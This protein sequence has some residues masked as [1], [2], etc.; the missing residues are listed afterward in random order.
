WHSRWAR[1]QVKRLLAGTVVVGLAVAGIVWAQPPKAQLSVL[2]SNNVE[3]CLAVAEAFEKQTGIT[4]HTV[5]LPTS[6]ALGRIRVSADQPEFDVWLGGPAES[7]VEAA[8]EDLLSPI[9]DLPAVKK[10]PH[11]LRD[12]NGYWAGVYGGILS[13]CVN[14]ELVSQ[15]PETWEDLLSSDYEDEILMSS[16]LLSG[17]ASTMLWVQY[18]RLGGTEGMVA[19]MKS[20]ER[21]LQGYLDSGT[22]VAR[23]VG[24]GNAAVGISFAPYCQAE[25][26]AGA[27]VELAYPEDGTGYEVGAVGLL[28]GSDNVQAGREFVN[29][30]VSPEGQVASTS[31]VPQSYTTMALSPNLIDELEVLPVPVLGGDVSQA[32]Q[33]RAQLITVWATEVRN[34]TY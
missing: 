14:T 2:C 33:V 10:L 16:P 1:G 18:S 27:P 31:Q 29:F 24:R 21:N 26:A 19:Y 7:Y 3:S 32:A 9:G 13:F 20:L 30:A 4:V 23:N 28:A 6:E 12:A 17:T 15:V 22:A 11:S 5:R 25:R 34:G 8:G